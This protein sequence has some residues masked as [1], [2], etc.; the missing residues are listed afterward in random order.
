MNLWT[1]LAMAALAA[2]SFHFASAQTAAGNTLAPAP[3][4]SDLSNFT[5]NSKTGQCKCSGREDCFD[6]GSSGLCVDGTVQDGN[7]PDSLMCEFK[8]KRPMRGTVRE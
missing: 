4:G 2:T 1:K 5:C 3:G 7:K 6:L 8:F